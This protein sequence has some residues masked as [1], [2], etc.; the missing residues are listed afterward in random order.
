MRTVKQL[1]ADVWRDPDPQGSP[2]MDCLD[3]HGPQETQRHVSS[4][5]DTRQASAART[6]QP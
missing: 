5:A 6:K 4:G 2:G 1:V 3:W